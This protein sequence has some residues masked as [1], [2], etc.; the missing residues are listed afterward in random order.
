MELFVLVVFWALLAWGVA[1]LANSRG[2]SSIGFFLLSFVLS[3]L[4]GL[5]VILI[6]RNLAEEDVKA[7]SRKLDTETKE[8][9]RNQEHERQLESIKAIA[10]PQLQRTTQVP[11]TPSIISSVAD[12][13]RK[14]GQLRAEGLLTDAEFQS[15]KSLL[16][17]HT[18]RKI[19][20]SQE[21]LSSE[22]KEPDV[23]ITHHLG[24]CPNCTSKIPL[25]SKKCPECTANFQ[26]GSIWVVKP[27]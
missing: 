14:L 12:E 15:Q 23:E 24:L 16:L 4:L 5:I 25:L 13:I 11:T 2:R 19:A 22:I 9:L 21:P 6:M 18:L 10:V 3:P 8:R 20:D 17:G 27:I 26:E 1:A 7:A